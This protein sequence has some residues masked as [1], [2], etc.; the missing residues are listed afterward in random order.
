MTEQGYLL[1]PRDYVDDPFLADSGL[2]SA[3]E[4][5]RI[6]TW[7]I[8][9]R[10]ELTN[11]LGYIQVRWFFNSAFDAIPLN[12]SL[13]EADTRRWK[14]N[15]MLIA[16]LKQNHVAWGNLYRG[17]LELDGTDHHI[18]TFMIPNFPEVPD[19]PDY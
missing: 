8:Y 4:L 5:E 7:K 16:A 9:S 3:T 14:G 13:F 19:D 12:D 10:R 2:P 15:E 6:R 1:I 17:Y 18:Y 11:L